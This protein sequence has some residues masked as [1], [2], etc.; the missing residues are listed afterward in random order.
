MLQIRIPQLFRIGPDVP[1]SLTVEAYSEDDSVAKVRIEGSGLTAVVIQ[2]P[3]GPGK[4]WMYVTVTN[5]G[6][7]VTVSFSVH[8]LALAMETPRPNDRLAPFTLSER[9]FP[10]R[11]YFRR[12]FSVEG[13]SSQGIAEVEVASVNA[14]SANVG[15]ATAEV[16]TGFLTLGYVLVTPGGP[17]KTRVEVTMRNAAGSATLA[18]PVT[19]AKARPL[20]VIHHPIPVTFLPGD[21]EE[22]IPHD[23]VFDP[24]GYTV[25]VRSANTGVVEAEV[26]PFYYGW[27]VLTSVEPGRTLVVVTARNAVSE[28]SLEVEVTVHEKIRLGLF[29][30]LGNPAAPVRLTEGAQWELDVRALNANIDSLQDLP[31]GP[32]SLA[33]NIVTD[34]PPSDLRI[35]ESVAIG[36]LLRELTATPVVIEAPAD[37]VVDEAEATYSVALAPNSELPDWVELSEEPVR[38]VVSDSPLAACED[39]QVDAVLEERSGG[40]FEGTLVVQSPHPDTKVSFASPYAVWG[41]GGRGA[42]LVT[43]VFPEV[44]NHRELSDGFEQ[45][46]R[47]RWWDDDLRLTVET[48]GCEPV[49]VVCDEVACEVE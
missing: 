44:L 17:G 26:Q 18:V 2:E 14:R 21:P 4:T 19:V 9:G 37:D 1:E 38:V 23:F 35:P 36:S 16:V 6:A 20:R 47:L 30:G 39:L 15:V 28:A 34:A 10:I 29:N 3:V 43:H 42:P 31:P 24:P 7:S 12:M 27:I 49:E 48:P 25:E 46:V 40:T 22:F 11:L 45:T 5:G 33:L 41:G 8:V 32:A 13:P